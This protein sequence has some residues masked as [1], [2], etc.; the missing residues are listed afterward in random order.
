MKK[1]IGIFAVYV[2]ALILMPVSAFAATGVSF[3]GKIISSRICTCGYT[4]TRI[5]IKPPRGSNINLDYT[6]GTQGFSKYNLPYG[7]QILGVYMP[8]PVPI[9]W[10]QQSYYCIPRYTPLALGFIIS[11]VGSSI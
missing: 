10:D 4:V 2:T 1:R 3:G 11:M 5:T 8:S 7:R 6:F 9:C